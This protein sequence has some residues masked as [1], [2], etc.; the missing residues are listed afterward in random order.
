MWMRRSLSDEEKDD[1]T[2]GSTLWF[3]EGKWQRIWLMPYKEYQEDEASMINKLKFMTSKGG[4]LL[5]TDSTM[6]STK[7]MLVDVGNKSLVEREIG[8]VPS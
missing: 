4:S 5:A 1:M 8:Q 6:I 7:E 3:V 2:I